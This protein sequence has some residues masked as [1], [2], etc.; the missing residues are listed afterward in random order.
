MDTF[1]LAL[2]S[3]E[4]VRDYNIEEIEFENQASETRLITA[5]PLIG[6]NCK[7]PAL[8]YAKL[9]DYID[10]YN[11][12]YGS[13]NQFY[14]TSRMDQTQYV[15]RFERGSFKTTNNSGYYQVEFRLKRVF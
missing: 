15:V 7:S 13:L 8:T 11:D 9:Q 3:S 6:F 14:F 12:Q 5:A 4:E 10:F 1:S 2:E